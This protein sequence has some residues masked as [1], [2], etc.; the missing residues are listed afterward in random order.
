MNLYAYV[1]NDPIDFIDSMGL[2]I[3][4]YN[5]YIVPT[6]PVVG[7]LITVFGRICWA[8]RSAAWDS[9]AAGSFAS[10]LLGAVG[11]A[12]GESSNEGSGEGGDQNRCPKT[13]I[14]PNAI[15]AALGGNAEIGL[16]KVGGAAATGSAGAVVNPNRGS[17]GGFIS[18]GR[19]SYHGGTVSGS[20]RQDASATVIGASA[21]AGFSWVLTNAQ[22]AQQL[23]GPF[24]TYALNI[25]IGPYQ[26]SGSLSVSGKIWQLNISPPGGGL[27]AGASYSKI[28][29]NTVATPGCK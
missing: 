28:K 11:I 29:T 24:T 5:Q 22:S 15:G 17:I 18:G 27:T 21:S 12:A 14:G 1:G 4:G 3:E 23:S 13:G 9:I 20:P 16:P 19:A 8:C 7:E 26:L 25:G 6:D 2:S 10:S